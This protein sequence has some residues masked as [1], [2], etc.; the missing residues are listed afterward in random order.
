M[1]PGKR[2]FGHRESH[3]TRHHPQAYATTSGIRNRFEARHSITTNRTQEEPVTL[4]RTG[5]R[6]APLSVSTD[7]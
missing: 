3:R 4:L 6:Y 2:I 7:I 5:A 1:E